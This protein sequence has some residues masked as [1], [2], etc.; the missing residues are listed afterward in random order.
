MIREIHKMKNVTVSFRRGKELIVG[1]EKKVPL[2]FLKESDRIPKVLSDGTKTDVIVIPK[3]RNLTYCNQE[4][5]GC[6]IHSIRHRPVVGGVSYA[7]SDSGAGTLGVFVKDSFDQSIVAL[8]CNHVIGPEL[9]P[10]SLLPFYWV[11]NVLDVDML[12]PSPLDGGEYPRDMVGT[13]KRAV[14]TI[15][16]PDGVNTVDVAIGTLEGSNI[17]RPGIQD[18]VRGGVFPFA[19]K[20]EYAAGNTVEKVGRTTGRSIG[21]ILST[22]ANG[23]VYFGAETPENTAYYENVIAITATERFTSGGDS[24]SGVFIKTGGQWKLIGILFAGSDDG[25]IALVSHISD[26]ADL[27]YIE[28]WDGAINVPDGSG[29]VIL[30]DGVCY[31]NAEEEAAGIITHSPDRIFDNCEDC[32]SNQSA[33][34]LFGN[35]I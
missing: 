13:G 2:S 26:I 16:G 34:T 7:P 20:L 31:Y 10:G 12:Q 33:N 30:V 19:E 18:L 29:D 3:M 9:G 25:L 5:G 28:E 15:F 32:L 35:V 4:N 14:G 22:E 27:L 17:F 8:T 11:S 21:T 1:V 23:N 6:D 24:G